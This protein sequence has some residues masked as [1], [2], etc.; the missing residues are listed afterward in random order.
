MDTIKAFF[1]EY[2]YSFFMMVVIGFVTA[3]ITEITVKKALNWLDEQLGEKGKKILAVVRIVVIQLATWG[4]VIL[5]T[6]ILVKNMPLPGGKVFYIIWMFL[7]GAYLFG[8]LYWL[9][10]FI[11]GLT[12]SS[13]EIFKMFLVYIIQYVF[14]MFG[15]KGILE[16]ISKLKNRQP[17]PKREKFD[18]VAGMEKLDENVYFDGSAYYNKKGVKL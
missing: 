7:W 16:L 3:I 11:P 4:Q 15:I 10:N 18:P 5:Y 8:A 12:R 14:S 13:Q 6:H 9:Y 2:G 17:K 1:S